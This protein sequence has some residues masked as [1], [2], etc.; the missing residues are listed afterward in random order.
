MIV[1]KFSPLRRGSP[2]LLQY[3]LSWAP[4]A[5]TLSR[6]R[7]TKEIIR[8]PQKHVSV[9]EAG[10]FQCVLDQHLV[11]WKK[12]RS[13]E[14]RFQQR[15]LFHSLII[16][17]II[18]SDDPTVILSIGPKYGTMNVG[19]PPVPSVV[20]F[21]VS[22]ATLRFVFSGNKLPLWNTKKKKRGEKKSKISISA[23]WR[24]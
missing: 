23:N 11:W 5:V 15:F 2:L 3:Y 22:L 12:H 19:T 4:A 18:R 14:L 16:V 1:L 7:T 6:V 24:K 21:R 17:Q 9:V 10:E 8:S 13:M 20:S